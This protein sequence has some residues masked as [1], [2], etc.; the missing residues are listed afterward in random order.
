MAAVPPDHLSDVLITE[1]LHRRVPHN[2]DYKREKLAIQELAHQM[3]DHPEGVMP[4]LVRLAMEACEAQS[5]GISLYEPDPPRIG[6]FRWHH[7]AG[8]FAKSRVILARAAS[9]STDERR[10]SWQGRNAS[11]LTWPGQ[12][13][14]SASAFCYRCTSPVPCRR[15]RF[16][17]SHMMSSTIL[18]LVTHG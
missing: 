18:T 11:T 5:A 15:E 10:S 9:S 8:H 3:V 1:Q 6:I 2:V 4:G 16:G 12:A 7:L 17:S 13:F 14:R